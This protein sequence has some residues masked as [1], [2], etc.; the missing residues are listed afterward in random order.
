MGKQEGNERT[1]AAA[2][3]AAGSWHGQVKFD[4]I[5]TQQEAEGAGCVGETSHGLRDGV[6][7]LAKSAAKSW[8]QCER[9]LQGYCDGE[10]LRWV[11]GGKYG[12]RTEKGNC[13]IQHRQ[14]IESINAKGIDISCRTFAK[15]SRRAAEGWAWQ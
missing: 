4:L 7:L 3:A 9:N 12:A 14:A 10:E 15:G 1:S 13:L 8:V 5:K 2:A 11:V 6:S